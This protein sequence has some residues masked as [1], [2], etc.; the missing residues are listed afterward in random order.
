MKLDKY[1]IFSA[2][3][4]L[5]SAVVGCTPTKSQVGQI[6]S[7][8]YTVSSSDNSLKPKSKVSKQKT[9]IKQTTDTQK[10]DPFNIYGD[11]MLNEAYDL[12]A[13]R[14]YPKHPAS[15][16]YIT[17]G[18][19]SWYG[20]GLNGNTTASGEIFDMNGMSAAHGRLPFGSIVVVTNEKNNL[21]VVVRI[22]DRTPSFHP[23]VIDVSYGVAYLLDMVEAGVVPVHLEIIRVG[24]E[25]PFFDN[26]SAGSGSAGTS[27]SGG[28]P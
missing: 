12:W 7:A 21:S 28:N 17:N 25:D 8:N 5:F 23:R 24:E 26:L 1:L 9:R 2:S 14:G 19:G 10:T 22:N 27:D 3:I 20:P 13:S 15:R 6:V 18:S 11:D 4:F 16:Q